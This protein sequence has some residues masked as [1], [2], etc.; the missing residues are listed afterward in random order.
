VR[1]GE[2]DA[3]LLA[4]AG[5]QRLG[6][7]HEVTEWLTPET[8]LPAPG[9][10]ALAVQCR[11]GDERMLELLAAID[12]PKTRAET[13]AERAFLSALGSGCT[14]PV[15]AYATSADGA[16]KPSN[17]VLQGHVVVRLL[18]LVASPD[19]LRVVRVAGDGRPGEI[20][21][22]VALEALASGADEILRRAGG[23]LRGRRIA[24]TR[25]REQAVPLADALERLGAT[26]AVVPLVAIEPLENAAELDAALRELDDYDWVVFTSANGVAAVR[27]RLAR[28]EGSLAG[29]QVAAVGP[30]T[31]AAVSTG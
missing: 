27:E 14:A 5:I 26:V 24:V 11:A 22:R 28:S 8:M 2:F 4:A 31:A 29:V 16:S 23:P 18:G 9:Q 17:T 1:D 6:L 20:A 19:G 7:E 25:P 15:A 12:D 30:S 10:G 21:E 3:A 13:T